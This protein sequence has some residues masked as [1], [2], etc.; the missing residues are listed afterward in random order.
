MN[1][2]K[3]GLIIL[4]ILILGGICFIIVNSK[5]KKQTVQN[6]TTLIGKGSTTNETTVTSDGSKKKTAEIKTLSSGTLYSLIDGD[7]KPDIVIGDNYFDTQLSDITLNFNDYKDK[8]IEIEGMYLENTPYTFVGRYSTSNMCPYCPVGYSYF[9]YQWDIDNK[10]N[11]ADKEDWIK[12]IGTLKQGTD[13]QYDYY[14]I[15]VLTL[16]V[17]N[18]KG[19]DT[20]SN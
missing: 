16:E 14:Y 5:T 12:V 3:I 4:L 6:N 7:I 10:P 11:L 9:E 19:K 20:V 17:M 13:G 8:I 15:D 18:Q 2:K 1:K